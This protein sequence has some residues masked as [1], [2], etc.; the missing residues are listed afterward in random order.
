MRNS[1]RPGAM[2]STVISLAERSG[3]ETLVRQAMNAVTAYIRDAHL[4][5]G[6]P[7]PGEMHF[8]QELGVSRAVMREAFGALAALRLIDVGNGRRPRVSAFDSAAIAAS[9]DHAVNTAQISVPQV[10]DV[11]RTLERRTAALA[12]MCRTDQEAEEI[13]RHAH[14]MVTHRNDFEVM[15]QHDVALHQAIA[16]A[17]H[18]VLFAQVV[19]SF[20]VLMT[21]AV[22]VAWKTRTSE[23]Q[24]A[25]VLDR[26]IMIAEA[27]AGR[28]PMAAEAAME[29]HFDDSIKRLLD[30]GMT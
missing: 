25:G 30:S 24:R 13:L 4:K 20:G 7:L 28:D 17:S 5:V 8:A 10:W 27:I 9:L 15:T 14:A 21:E 11:R 6:D 23:E 12:A 18:N 2:S 16:R 1:N 22:P 29:G 19:A 3:P 26:H